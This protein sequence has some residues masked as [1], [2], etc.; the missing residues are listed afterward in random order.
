MS[1]QIHK[2]VTKV[3]AAVFVAVVVDV[4]VFVIVVLV[5][6]VAGRLIYQSI[7]VV[8]AIRMHNIP[9]QLKVFN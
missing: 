2:L 3:P 5:V 1:L 4:L 9:C 7:G 6:F 8:G